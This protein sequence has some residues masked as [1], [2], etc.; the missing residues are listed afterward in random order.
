[1]SKEI[2]ISLLHWLICILDISNQLAGW[3]PIGFTDF[4]G[5]KREI[6]ELSQLVPYDIRELSGTETSWEQVARIAR[7]KQSVSFGTSS[8]CNFASVSPFS[9]AQYHGY[10]LQV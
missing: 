9:K 1:M 6:A 3:I 7:E 8:L 10:C 4:D 2:S 5:F